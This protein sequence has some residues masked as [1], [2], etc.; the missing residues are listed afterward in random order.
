M[1]IK[2]FFVLSL[3]LFAAN[4]FSQTYLTQ[5]K[6]T[7]TKKW[8]YANQKG[9]II[10]PAQFERCYEFTR[11]GFAAIHDKESKAFYFINLKGEKLTTQ[12]KGIDGVEEG[13]SNGLAAVKT[14]DKWGYLDTSGKLAIPAKYDDATVFD[15]GYAVAKSGNKY[16]VLNARG[17]ESPVE[18][19]GILEVKHF[20]EKRA[21]FRATDKKFGFVD[22]H[23]KVAIQAK[24]Q[25]VGYFK[26]G[27]A[28]AK[29]E[30]AILGYIDPKGEWV[31]KPQFDAGREFDSGT[32]LARIKAADKWGYVNRSGQITN[33]NDTEVWGDFSDGLAEGKKGGK[34]GFYDS[35]GTWVIAPQFDGVRDFKNGFAAAKM[36]DQWGMIDK[37]GKWVIK[38]SFAGIKDMELVK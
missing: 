21:P 24:F 8:G 11:D 12:L 3:V 1:K 30:D 27:L 26:N 25:S 18:G 35:K 36:N 19:S 13:F 6:S 9:E 32:G 14:G 20:S 22:E 33:I 29:E 15:G 2:S 37:T 4:G 5:I 28:W 7:D 31:I 38:P 17:E 23:G 34:R 16:V 10:I